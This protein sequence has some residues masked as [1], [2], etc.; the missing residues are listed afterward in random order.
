MK[1]ALAI[2]LLPA[3]GFVLG[4]L[5][6]SMHLGAYANM[7]SSELEL[8]SDGWLISCAVALALL[9]PLELIRRFHI[10]NAR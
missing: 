5:C 2:S 7:D 3:I 10:R 8:V 4:V 9:V 6:L 1:H